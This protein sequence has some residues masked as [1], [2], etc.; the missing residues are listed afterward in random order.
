MQP[1]K[2]VAIFCYHESPLVNHVLGLQAG[3]QS[4]GIDVATGFSYLDGGRLATFLDTF[5]P[6]F[7]IEINRSRN[8]IT[9]YQEK[10]HHI[11]WVQDNATFSA[12]VSWQFGGSDMS[13][14]VLDP[15]ILGYDVERIGRWDLLPMAVEPRLYHPIDLPAAWD[16]TTIGYLAEP[17]L[18]HERHQKFRVGEKTV[19]I[20]D[21]YDAFLK[22]GNVMANFHMKNIEDF[23]VKY[24]RLQ[25]PD[26]QKDDVLEQLMIFF[27]D[28]VIRA[29][30]RSIFMK[31]II[32]LTNNVRIFGNGHWKNDPI[33]CNYFGGPVY[34][35]DQKLKIYN[36]SKVVFHN[37]VLHMHERVFEAMACGRPVLMNTT[38]YDNTPSGIA[39]HFTPDEHFIFFDAGNLEEVTHALLRDEPRRRKIGEQA[40]ERCLAG[41]TWRHRAEKILN[42]YL[43]R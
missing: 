27:E 7:V 14:F 26:Y 3:F 1:V 38:P 33:L 17:L 31:R 34:K 35:P 23:I 11:A 5:Q 10:L 29:L 41:H 16:V 30:D 21:L 37:G 9:D 42:D 4:M 22:S 18:E 39:Y 20:A 6:D 2:R 19:K 12:R 13:Y 40:R 25:C 43:S 36:L 32:N 8:H 15:D 24:L 28:R